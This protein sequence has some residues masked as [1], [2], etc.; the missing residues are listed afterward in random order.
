MCVVDLFGFDWYRGRRGEFYYPNPSGELAVML[1]G[2]RVG[3]CIVR[4]YV[5]QVRYD[6]LRMVHRIL[7][8]DDPLMA[9]GLGLSPLTDTPL[10]ETVA[11]NIR[12]DGKPLYK[13]GEFTYR[14]PIDPYKLL[15]E[16]RS[17]GYGVKLS[18]TLGTYLCNGLAYTLY[19]WSSETGRKSVFIHIPPV[20]TLNVRIN[21]VIV[22][23]SYWSI[24]VLGNMILSIIDIL[25]NI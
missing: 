10:I 4:G 20:G 13:R 18:N 25:Y 24:D 22:G 7:R 17:R 14:I 12:S 2:R 11:V 5:I 21:R 3:E 6:S 23:R 16:L 19:M 9:I 15:E 1:N 8:R